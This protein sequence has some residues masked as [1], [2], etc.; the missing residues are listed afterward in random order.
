MGCFFQFGLRQQLIGNLDYN[1]DDQ[2]ADYRDNQSFG[3]DA[4]QIYTDACT[5]KLYIA[6]KGIPSIHDN[7]S[8]L[9]VDASIIA[10]FFRESR[11][12]CKT[13]PF[14]LTFFLL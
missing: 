14:L 2:K 12:F 11:R 5:P 10:D 13:T 7:A 1:A 4:E 9:L 8:P 6:D 3:N